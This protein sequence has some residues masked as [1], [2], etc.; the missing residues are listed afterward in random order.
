MNTKQTLGLCTVLLFALFAAV[1]QA[2]P[3]K[4]VFNVRQD[5]DSMDVLA[6]VDA[7]EEEYVD[8]EDADEDDYVDDEDEAEE[9]EDEAEEYVEEDEAEEDVEEDVEEAEDEAEEDVEEDVEEAEDE[10]EEDVEE[11]VEEAE[12]EAEEDVEEDVE[13]AEDEAEEDVEEDVEEAEDEA[14]EDVEEDVEE[15]EDEAE[16]DVEEDVEEAEDEAEEDVE[17]D[18]EEAEDEAEEDVEEDVEE[19][20]DEAEEDVEEDVEEAEDEAEEDVEEADPLDGIEEDDE[21]L[22]VVEDDD[23]EVVEDDDEEVVEDDDEDGD[24]FVEDEDDLDELEEDDGIEE[25]DPLDELDEDAGLDD[26][27]TDEDDEPF[28]LDE[29]EG[30]GEGDTAPAAAAAEVDPL[31]KSLSEIALLEEIRRRMFDQHGRE[32]LEEGQR[33]VQNGSWGLA[34]EK[35]QNALEF[36][37]DKESTHGLRQQAYEG[38]A[39]AYYRM[40]LEQ[41][42]FKSYEEAEKSIREARGYIDTTSPIWAKL[43]SL[44]KKVRDLQEHP[45]VEPPPPRVPRW[46]QDDFRKQ[47]D[48]FSKRLSVAREHYATGEYRDARMHVEEILKKDPYYKPALDLLRKIHVVEHR[49]AADEFRATREGMIKNVTASWTAR[50]NYGTEFKSLGVEAQ[51]VDPNEANK[52]LERTTDEVRIREKMERIMLDSIEYRQANI[53]DVINELSDLSRENDTSEAAAEEKGINF[54]LNVGP[55][56]GAADT[57]AAAGGEEDFWGESAGG[58]SAGD[59]SYAGI[60]PLTIKLR[61]ISLKTALDTIMEMSGLKYRINGNIVMIMRKN[62]TT[63]EMQHRMYSVLPSIQEVQLQIGGSRAGGSGG[64]DDPWQLSGGERKAN[65]DWKT[66]FGDL[67]VAWPDGSSIKYMPTIGKLVVRNTPDNLATLEQV[68]GALNVTP[69]QVEIEVRF[70]EVSQLDLN[71]LGLEWILNDDY[72]LVE[73]KND[74]GLPVASRRRGVIESGNFNRGFNYLNR[75][76]RLG[77][78]DGSGIMDNIATFTSILSNPEF[79]VVL[80]ALSN[81]SNTDMLSAPKVT[82]RTGTTATI[83]TVTEYVYPTEYEV[84]WPEESDSNTVILQDGS[85]GSMMLPAVEPQEF[86][87]REV[88]VILQVTPSVSS[89]GTRISLDLTPTVVSDPSWKDYGYTYP[90]DY[91]SGEG[92]HLTMEQPFFPVRSLATSVD[93][94]N[95]CTVVM[96]GMIREERFTEEDKIPILGDIPLIGALFRYK[97]EQSD[98]RN[99][100]IFV[101]ARLV[102]PAGREITG[103]AADLL[104]GVQSDT[105]Q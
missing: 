78:N 103:G 12:D 46:A 88:G 37:Q 19:A 81:R 83:K 40:A 52:R 4:A 60:P 70:V 1:S 47:R 41:T 8:D 7:D 5:V 77:V 18:V 58:E 99:L 9:D 49:Y 102:D 15:A 65:D 23:E 14:E 11:D 80:H 10:A 91:R 31:E 50:N 66:F 42:D 104:T 2:K 89:D 32:S 73:N 64:S 76:T 86:S 72:E 3:P 67:G 62:A 22:A 69:F 56:T 90:I 85:S 51:V 74:R 20:E 68:L 55:D 93:I 96:G 54:M 53:V 61:Y 36:L 26:T 34:I 38:L 87:T 29:D 95:G 17:E 84:K 92:F 82:A 71:S 6:D 43:E 35:F 25:A 44:L 100:L 75:N 13:E 63:E 16:E 45:P 79:S 28:T 48:D 33:A 39:E 57:A 30:D 94:Y 101:T 97:Y 105:K 21:D 24:E 98:K 27:E 59:G